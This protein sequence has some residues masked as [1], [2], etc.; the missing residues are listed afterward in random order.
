MLNCIIETILPNSGMKRP[1]T[2]ASFMRRK[3]TAGWRFEVSIDR[4]SR[5]ASSS[6]RRSALI[7]L[8]DRVTRLSASGWNSSS[9]ISARW[10]I[11]MMLTGSRL[12]TS[13]SA[14][15]IR[16]L[17]SMKIQRA[18]DLAGPAG[19]TAHDAGKPWRL[20]GLLVLK[21]GAENSGQ[22]AD[23]LGDQKIVLHEPFDRGK[24]GMVLIAETLGDIAL[25]VEGEPLF[26]LAGEEMHVA[27]HR[28]EEIFGL[29][30]P[31]EFAAGQHVRDPT[32]SVVS[33]IW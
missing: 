32:R 21:P 29:F 8:S 24:A 10:N 4:N 20:F 1:S 28:P 16:P 30:E 9:R 27:A 11:R 25:N 7:I 17:S 14:R 18:G 6:F 13:A 22:V 5:L 26:G 33:R 23:I 12:N 31:L 15:L 19:K 3:M 2:P